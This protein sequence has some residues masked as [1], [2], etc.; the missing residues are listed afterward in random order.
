MSYQRIGTPKIYV[1]NLNWLFALG[2]ID[3]TDFSFSSSGSVDLSTNSDK[4]GMFDMK[5]SNLQQINCNT[6][7]DTLFITVD[8]HITTDS[9]VDNNFVAILGH[10]FL[11]AGAKFQ[12][13]QSDNNFS[14]TFDV[15]NSTA[16]VS[17]SVVSGF[18]RPENNGWSLITF[19]DRT[20]DNDNRYWRVRIEPSGSIYSANLQIG[21][22]LMGET[23]SLPRSPDLQINRQF[24]FD[25]VTKQT[26]VGG[27]TY[28]NAQYL[29]GADWFLD[30]FNLSST[31]TTPDPLRKTGR[32]SWDMNFSYL[33]DTD[34]FPETLY[35][36]DG[37]IQG[38]DFYTNLIAKTHG[39]M[40]PFLFQYD[41]TLTDGQDSFLWCRLNNEP[42][43]QQVANRVWNTSINL[44]EEF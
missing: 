1:D 14:N 32:Q 25:G 20:G 38:N 11:E 5:P 2:K 12:I 31:R 10:N 27:Q 3:D 29:S 26:S 18:H 30:P 22:I 17:A 16:V 21:A 33:A 39:G 44:I 13:E 42:Q 28:A 35:S 43:F 6:A 36:A 23:I 9:Q 15:G 37:I 19:T 24:I 4:M 40:L 41:N 8:T 7:N 34:T